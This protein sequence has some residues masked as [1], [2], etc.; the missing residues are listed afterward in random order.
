MLECEFFWIENGITLLCIFLKKSSVFRHAPILF[1]H[2]VII[3]T[4]D[5]AIH[6]KPLNTTSIQN[7]IQR[8]EKELFKALG[9]Y[10][11]KYDY[12]ELSVAW[13]NNPNES[14]IGALATWKGRMD[15][16]KKR[17]ALIANRWSNK[18]YKEKKTLLSSEKSRSG[19]FCQ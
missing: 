14:K 6:K 10:K 17:I 11:K 2:P 9:G 3:N 18:S 5:F 15:H 12:L 7:I 19:H 1:S 16:L 8:I 4:W 13:R